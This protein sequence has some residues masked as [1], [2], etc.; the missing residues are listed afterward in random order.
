MERQDVD[1][2]HEWFNRINYAC[3]YD[4][5]PVQKSKAERLRQFDNPSQLA[6]LTERGRFVIEKKDGTKIGFIA[7]WLTQPNRI[8]EIGYDLVPNERGKG[9]GTEAVQIMVDYLFLSRNIMRIQAL[10]N[11]KNVPSQ[12]V[13]EKVGFKREGTIRKAGFTRGTWDDAYLY[14]IVREEWKEPRILTKAT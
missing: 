7:H 2:A 13:L 9:Y 3:E 12:R 4:S 10:T 5:I 8:M 14:G 11:V 1:F 6:L